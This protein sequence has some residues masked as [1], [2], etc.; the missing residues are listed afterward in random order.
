MSTE[1]LATEAWAIIYQVR[2]HPNIIRTTL[3]TW[4]DRDVQWVRRLVQGKYYATVPEW[5]LPSQRIES[6]LNRGL[7]EQEPSGDSP[8]LGQRAQD[9]TVP[10]T[11][12]PG[13]AA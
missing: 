2:K 1:L 11:R 7:L 3:G 13:A 4:T 8:A 10:R 5:D 6:M 12:G 9:I